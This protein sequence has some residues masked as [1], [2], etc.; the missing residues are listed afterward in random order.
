MLTFEY[1][2]KVIKKKEKKCDQLCL[3]KLMW[4]MCCHLLNALRT[5]AAQ[6]DESFIC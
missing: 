1:F 3:T 5:L 6:R 4:C 2:F